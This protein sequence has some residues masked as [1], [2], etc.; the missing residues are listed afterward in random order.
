MATLVQ[1]A[2]SGHGDC[3]SAD[4]RCKC[5]KADPRTNTFWIGGD[6]SLRECPRGPA[7]VDVA[8]GVDNAHNVAECSNKGNC[9]YTTG[10]C[11]CEL[12]F[13]GVS[14]NRMTCEL[15]CN[16]HGAC[17]SMKF[18][19]EAQT[20]ANG[21]TFYSYT[22]VWDADMIYGCACDEGY[23]GHDCSIRLCP[24]G[25]DPMTSGQVD[26]VQIVSCT[27]Q[28][29]LVVDT[30]PLRTKGKQR[31]IS[32]QLGRIRPTTPYKQH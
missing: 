13:E 3:S 23:T 7:W 18:H 15:D 28:L 1:N 10:H 26:E 4:N 22:N 9:D 19:S 31:H 8:I 17:R 20:P 12:N 27:H 14:C 32:L 21:K 24:T 30:S 29:E 5:W 16:G 2:C 11:T 25:D 6:C